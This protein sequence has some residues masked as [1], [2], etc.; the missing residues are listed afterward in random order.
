[1]AAAGKTKIV[2]VGW[3]HE[4]CMAPLYASIGSYRSTAPDLDIQWDTR[5]LKDFGDGNLEAHAE[6][7]DLLIFDHP[8]V[9]AAA[10]GG[11]LVDW[12]ELLS[13][14]E[15]EAFA[16][17]SLGPCFE[18]YRSG[19]GIWGLPIDAAAQVSALRQDLMEK[20][21]L[22]HPRTG[23][24]V[25]RLA[26][27]ARRHG[28][29]MALPSVPIDA[30]SSFL[31][32]CANLGDPVPRTPTGFPRRETVLTVLQTLSELVAHAHPNSLSWNPITCYNYMTATDDVCYVPFAYGYSNYSRPAA[33]RRLQF[34]DIPVFG[35]QGP[36]GAILGG[37]GIGISRKCR[38]IEAAKDYALYLTRPAYQAGEYTASGGQP[39]SLT[40]W[41]D[42][43]C[44]AVTRGYFSGTLETLTRAYLRPTFD[45]FVPY[46]K[47]AG[48]LINEFLRKRLALTAVADKLETDFL[49]LSQR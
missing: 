13:P 19:D 39:A 1:M 30:I 43:A 14:A 44:D 8:Y 42:P 38:N 23:E 9:G 46:F 16:K 35:T 34:T 27:D 3:D 7:Y 17:D 33:G 31:T 15:L 22:P 28:L 10:A 25:I 48:E 11:W 4:R 21:D 12:T 5:S 47:A 41:R 36:V 37:A 45:G 6:R 2:G 29:W 49:S 18:S 32:L 40:A 24:D 20:F 26:K